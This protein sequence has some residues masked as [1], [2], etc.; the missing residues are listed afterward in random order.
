VAIGSQ[1]VFALLS[2]QPQFNHFMNTILAYVLISI[3]SILYWQ[4]GFKLNFMLNINR[5]CSEGKK[6]NR[7]KMLL[8]ILMLIIGIITLAT[9]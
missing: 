7:E 2:D 1:G 8:G 5:F 4:N 3:G 6:C 9:K